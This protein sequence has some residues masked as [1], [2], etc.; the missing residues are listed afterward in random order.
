MRLFVPLNRQE[1]E[2][3]ERLAYAERRRPQ[4]QAASILARV[5]ANDPSA[6]RPNQCAPT[7]HGRDESREPKRVGP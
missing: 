5:L 2:S 1:Y 3:L 7:E 4:D 6:P